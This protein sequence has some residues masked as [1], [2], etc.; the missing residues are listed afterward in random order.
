MAAHLLIAHSAWASA[1]TNSSIIDVMPTGGKIGNAAP[2]R[3]ANVS[4]TAAEKHWLN[5]DIVVVN[6]DFSPHAPRDHNGDAG[7][8]RQSGFNVTR[9]EAAGIASRK[10]AVL[11]LL[12][13][14]QVDFAL[15]RALPPVFEEF[16]R[17][18]QK[19]V[20]SEVG[21]WIP[22]EW[23]KLRLTPGPVFRRGSA[24][25]VS[26]RLQAFSRGE[27]DA[28]HAQLRVAAVRLRR[29]LVSSIA[30]VPGISA[31]CTGH[32]AVTDVTVARAEEI[33]QRAEPLEDRASIS[34][35]LPIPALSAAPLV[36]VIAA[37]AASCLLLVVLL[38]LPAS[39]SSSYPRHPSHVALAAGATGDPSKQ[40]SMLSGQLGLT[41][42][43]SRIDPSRELATRPSK[44]KKEKK[45]PQDRTEE[46]D[47]LQPR[48][49]TLPCPPTPQELSAGDEAKTARSRGWS[50]IFEVLPEQEPLAQPQ[51]NVHVR[52]PRGESDTDV[53]LA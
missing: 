53:L 19:A 21:Y 35:G 29:R 48:Q 31:A 30:G 46:A 49:P 23:I 41:M 25:R 6:P 42:A 17:H 47:P 4:T 27:A 40:Y 22:P 26:A 38:P 13:V 14:Q 2:P 7:A 34:A 24:L 39:L 9:R 43:T 44:E 12:T 1:P 15:L 50:S 33:V 51:T 16:Q 37:S 18:V 10:A 32:V 20:A 5:T 8:S 28:W 45:I 36:L 3:G 11:I 52:R